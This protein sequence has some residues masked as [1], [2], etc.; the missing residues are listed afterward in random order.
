MKRFWPRQESMLKKLLKE[1]KKYPFVY[2]L[3]GIILGTAFVLRVYR[4]ND[5]LNF[6]YDQGRDALVIWD[7]I[8]NGKWFLI[9]PTTGLAG[10]FRGPY[11]Y[12]LIAPFYLI[13]RGNPVYPSVFLSLTTVTAIGFIYYL[14]FRIQG[15]M[16][17]LIAAAVASFSFY[18]V[19]AS[20]WLSNP[21]PM[22]L[23]SMVLVWGMLKVTDG[24]KW[25]WS[26]IAAC[27]G[28]SLFNF[29]SAGELFYF[30]AIFVFAIWQRKNWPDLKN[31]LLSMFLFIMTFAPLV[32]FD[33]KHEHILWNNIYKTFVA[34]KSFILPT[35][36]LWEIRTPFYYDVF[37]NKLFDS[38]GIREQVVMGIVAL[39]LFISLSKFFKNKGYL[40]LFLLLISPIVG[41]YFYQGNETVLYDYYLTGYYLIFILLFSCVLGDIWR[42][43][44]G[45]LF[46]LYFFY[47]FLTSNL[48]ILI[49][50]LTDKAV[51]PGSLD[52]I[53]QKQ[54][55]D[56]IY[57]DAGTHDFNVDE[58][59]PP[60]IPYAYNYLFMW[61][62]TEKY[63]KLPLET[64]VPLLYT[65]REID[66]PHPD[67]I[68][69]WIARQ[70]GIGKIESTTEFGG[71]TVERRIRY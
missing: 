29:G 60:V 65:L 64:R 43:K 5:L 61:L 28:L 54:A 21:T 32:V 48:S 70:K 41:L 51:G 10:I 12:Y 8:H 49:P 45:K 55:I 24:K 33:L 26:V 31:F 46:V 35:K 50:R 44:L 40:I 27:A 4:I 23:L 1:I 47:L 16:A 14:G 38:R 68:N 39:W 53:N 58:Y 42:F 13:G 36:Y 18:I 25:G 20:K 59:V 63:H 22:L 15:R 52:F 9:G 6:Y 2:V 34:E 69:A 66:P 19:I 57:K 17:G 37:T 11:Y 71:I 67:R 7:L 3:L 62:G 30:P 56:W